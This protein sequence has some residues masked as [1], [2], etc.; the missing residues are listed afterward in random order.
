M[1]RVVCDKVAS[2]CKAKVD[3]TKCHACHAK[4][5]GDGVCVSVCVCVCVTKLCVKDGGWQSCVSKGVCDKVVCVK[6]GGWQSMVC[7]KVV[8]DKVVC[9]RWCVTKLCVT[10]MVCDKVV[11]DK[12][13]CER[14]C[15]TKW[16]VTKMV[17]DKVVCDKDGV[18][19]SCVWQSCVWKMVCDKVVCVKDCVCVWQSCGWQNAAPR[20]LTAPKRAGG[21]GS[22]GIQNQKQEPHTKMWGTRKQNKRRMF[23]IAK[24]SWWGDDLVPAS[25]FRTQTE[26]VHFKWRN[27]CMDSWRFEAKGRKNGPDKWRVLRKHE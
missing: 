24:I 13:V 12:V 11:C 16:C 26:V 6:D 9:E 2:F 21:G 18:W 23:C 8:C 5:R 19:Q 10:K 15:V 25:S 4:W 7:D 17:C 22:G 1:W 27:F 20:A 3:I 14:W